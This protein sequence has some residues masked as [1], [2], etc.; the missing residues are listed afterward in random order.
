MG[1]NIQLLNL[2]HKLTRL[3][4]V[5]HCTQPK[6]KNKVEIVGFNNHRNRDNTLKLRQ[7]RLEPF[8]NGKGFQ[9]LNTS[10]RQDGQTTCRQEKSESHPTLPSFDQEVEFRC[11]SLQVLSLSKVKTPPLFSNQTPL[12]VRRLFSTEHHDLGQTRNASPNFYS[13]IYPTTGQLLIFGLLP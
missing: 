7:Q 8:D 4:E 12:N 9:I 11:L 3:R 1:R 2:N 10:L 5:V 6:H 13:S